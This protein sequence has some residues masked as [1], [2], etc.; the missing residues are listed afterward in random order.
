MSK[1][2][3]LTGLAAFTRKPPA[4]QQQPDTVA[5]KAATP[6]AQVA[7]PGEKKK[8][9]TG[10]MVSMTVRLS[11]ADWERLHQLAVSERTSIQRLAIEGFSK[12]F[13]EK[14]LPGMTS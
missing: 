6:A 10:D 5:E 4:Q 11:R 12:V 8:R 14:G 1:A 3:T 2:P 9:G 13:A 7:Q